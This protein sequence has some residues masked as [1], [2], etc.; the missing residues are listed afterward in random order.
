MAEEELIVKMTLQDELTRQAQSAS[1]TVGKLTREMEKARQEGE[2]TGDYSNYDRLQKEVGQSTREM[3]TLKLRAKDAGREVK[4]LETT[5]VRSASRMQSAWKRLS[6]VMRS[7]LFT[8]ATVAGV[9]LFGKR[10]VEAFAQAEQSQLKLVEAYRKF[11]G[12]GNVPI[13]SIRALAS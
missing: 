11:D 3:V 9:A 1:K 2:R 4:K 7:P 10:A 6:G 13:D 8:A 5:A 12:I